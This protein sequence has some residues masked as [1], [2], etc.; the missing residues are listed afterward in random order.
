[1]R[2]LPSV[3]C[4]FEYAVCL[5]SDGSVYCFGGSSNEKDEDVNTLIFTPKKISSL[6]CISGIACGGSHTACL[7]YDGNV[8]IFGKNHF[9]QLGIGVDENTLRGTCI[10]QKVNLPPCTQIS[11]GY[12]FTMCLLEDGR[13]Y[14]F[15][16]NVNG[17]LGLGNFEKSYNTPQ[18]IESIKDIE[19]IECGGN[20]TFCKTINNEIYCWGY[21][22]HGQLGLGNRHTQNFPI[23]CYSLSNENVVDIKC[24]S[25]HTLALKSNQQVYSCGNNSGGILGRRSDNYSES[26]FQR[27]D[28]LSEIIR[29]ECGNSESICIDINNYIYILCDDGHGELS[30]RDRRYKPAKHPTLSNVIDISHG[31]SNIFVKTSNNEIYNLK[32][33]VKNKFTTIRVFEGNEDIWYSNIK[34]KAKSARF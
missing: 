11:C 8:F 25:Y 13:L 7:D 26:R 14:S 24:G 2:S 27:V 18:L 23:V 5:S 19:F 30:D 10:P 29:I 32:Y 6:S 12:N 21:N 33:T 16:D 31:G 15:G 34:S 17:Q 28:N 22:Y 9:G 3:V 4:A 20:H 1:M